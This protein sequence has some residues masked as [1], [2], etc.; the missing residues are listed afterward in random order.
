MQQYEEL[1][2]ELRAM[3]P[4]LEAEYG[5]AEIGLFGSYVRGEQEEDSDL[6]VLVSFEEPIGLLALVRMENE[7]AERLGIDVDLVTEDSLKPRIRERVIADV[8]YA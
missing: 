7:L 5:V 8:V 2:D 3:K 6:D 4:Y 1:Q